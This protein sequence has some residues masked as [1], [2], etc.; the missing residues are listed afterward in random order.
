[1]IDAALAEWDQSHA[2][3]MLS[4]A[5]KATAICLIGAFIVVGKSEKKEEV[6]ITCFTCLIRPEHT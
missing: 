2:A 1:L 5:D 6:S 4:I 3:L